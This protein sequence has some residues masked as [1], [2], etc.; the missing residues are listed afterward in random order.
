MPHTFM[1][2]E[3]STMWSALVSKSVSLLYLTV[4]RANEHRSGSAGY[5]LRRGRQELHALST[6]SVNS[7]VGQGRHPEPTPTYPLHTSR[8]GAGQ[9]DSSLQSDQHSLRGDRSALL[10]AIIT[11]GQSPQDRLVAGT[12]TSTASDLAS[13]SFVR[14]A[15]SSRKEK[16]RV[17]ALLGPHSSLPIGVFTSSFLVNV[18]LSRGAPPFFSRPSR[19]SLL[20]PPGDAHWTGT[21]VIARRRADPPAGRPA[22]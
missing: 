6:E 18:N 9:A 12:A 4:S 2:P 15:G 8:P 22:G 13:L 10:Y 1:A 17:G 19:P 5:F 20:S 11:R 7:S 16:K 3:S 21:K 14:V